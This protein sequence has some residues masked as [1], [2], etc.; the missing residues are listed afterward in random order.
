MA[1]HPLFKDRVDEMITEYE[2]IL[3]PKPKYK[4]KTMMMDSDDETISSA[5]D[6]NT[7]LNPTNYNLT[8]K[9]KITAV[10]VSMLADSI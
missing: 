1:Y 10:I 4:Y 9:S 2:N 8:K 5:A 3:L 7:Q 6:N